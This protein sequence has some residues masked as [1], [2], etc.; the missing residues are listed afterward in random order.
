MKRKLLIINDESSFLLFAKQ[1]KI[2]SVKQTTNDRKGRIISSIFEIRSI[3]EDWCLDWTFGVEGSSHPS[4]RMQKLGQKYLHGNAICKTKAAFSLPSC[5]VRQNFSC[6]IDIW[7]T[8]IPKSLW[9][10]PRM[11]WAHCYP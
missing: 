9:S 4:W 1:D 3:L 2:D 6:E 10:N 5:K 8:S 7:Y 11:P